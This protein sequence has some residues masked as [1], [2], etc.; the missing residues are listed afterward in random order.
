M[1]GQSAK[2]GAVST[3][4]VA[5]YGAKQRICYYLFINQILSNCYILADY[6]YFIYPLLSITEA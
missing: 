5:F 4:N 1:I 2:G 3:P 6:D